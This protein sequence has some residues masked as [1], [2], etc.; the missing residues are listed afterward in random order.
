MQPRKPKLPAWVSE[1][2]PGWTLSPSV[3][4]LMAAIICGLVIWLALEHRGAD[5]S[6]RMLADEQ[7]GVVRMAAGALEA[8]L[9]MPLSQAAIM[10]RYDLGE[11]FQGQGAIGSVVDRLQAGLAAYPDVI[12]YTLVDIGGE[13]VYAQGIESEAGDAAINRSLEWVKQLRLDAA[14]PPDAV[15]MTTP[16]TAASLTTIGQL[17]PVR[18]RDETVG[19]LIVAIDI[20][21]AA[22]RVFEPAKDRVSG[23]F[24]LMDSRGA[25]LHQTG[26][27]AAGAALNQVRR[28][29]L[30]D[31]LARMRQERSGTVV[32][33]QTG[34]LSGLLPPRMLVSWDHLMVG[35]GSFVVCRT[36][37]MRR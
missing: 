13:L 3:V 26:H 30:D 4:L 20:R 28:E 32:C 29:D 14:M 16:E 36:A 21:K 11:F 23:C 25:I 31:L 8:S 15:T 1:R 2:I 27:K 12:A 6:R 17:F 9:G 22:A 34:A 24:H 19:A 35:P 18:L 7:A 33:R 5:G 37:P 10:A